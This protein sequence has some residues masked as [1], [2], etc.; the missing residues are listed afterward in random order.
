MKKFT[1]DKIIELKK[2]IHNLELQESL[3][4]NFCDDP[5]NINFV[6]ENNNDIGNQFTYLHD[7]I[8]SINKEIQDIRRREYNIKVDRITKNLMANN[9]D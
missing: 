8:M 2:E 9:I 7:Q 3:M 5:R 1:S 4:H 6:V